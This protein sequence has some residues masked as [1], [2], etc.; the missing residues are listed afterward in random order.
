LKLLIRK[1]A[2]MKCAQFFR[3][4][5]KRPK[6]VGT[7][8]PSSQILSKEMARQIDG[9]SNVIEFGGGQG[10]VTLQIL[11]RLPENGRLTSFE[12]NPNFCEDLQGINDPRLKVINDDAANCE[13]Y[14]DSVDYIVSSLPLRVFEKSHRTRILDISSKSKKYVQLQYSPFLRKRLDSYFK[15]IRTKFV[16]RNIPPAI[17]YICEASTKSVPSDAHPSLIKV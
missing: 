8:N 1:V 9:A 17:I 11:K 2:K 3:E 13:R 15:K 4:F 6:Q 10:A 16:L 12:I 14:L 5:I 7:L